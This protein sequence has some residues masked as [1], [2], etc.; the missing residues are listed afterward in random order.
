MSLLTD[1]V[2]LVEGVSG[3]SWL[4]STIV[5][6][7]PFTAAVLSPMIP[8]LAL[9]V[10][11]SQLQLFGSLPF[12][13]TG[14][15]PLLVQVTDHAAVVTTFVLP[16]EIIPAWELDPDEIDAYSGSL[17]EFYYAL[18]GGPLRQEML[19]GQ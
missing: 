10:S 3:F 18:M 4:S 15:W 16:V 13:V 7:A 1:S 5:G 8:G 12:G 11:G 2:S 19:G 6:A 9:V 17:G 14:A